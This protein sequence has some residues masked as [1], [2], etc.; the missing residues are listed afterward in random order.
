MQIAGKELA[1]LARF[2]THVPGL[3]EVL[4]GGLFESGV[5]IVQGSPGVGK[6]TLGNQICFA[7][8]RSGGRALYLTLL[9]ESHARMMQH[10][11]AQT[12]FDPSAIPARIYYI[13]AYRELESDGLKGILALLR[14]ELVRQHASLLVI[15][16]VLMP[17]DSDGAAEQRMKEFVHELQSVA[18]ILG[19]NVLMLTSGRGRSFDP[20]QTMVD[21]IFLMEDRAYGMREERVFQVSKFRGSRTARGRHSYCITNHGVHI[22][23]RLEGMP[24]EEP[25]EAACVR[26]VTSG[27]PALDALFSPPG[28]GNATCTLVQGPGGTGKTLLGLQF[29]SKCS[30][31]EPGLMLCF[32]EPRVRLAEMAASIGLDFAA[33][34]ERGHAQVRWICP[35]DQVLDQLGHELLAEIDTGRV[36]RLVVDGIAGLADTSMFHERGYRFLSALLHE[37]RCRGVTA[38]FVSD[39]DALA[40]LGVAHVSHGLAVLFDNVID[41][42]L[43]GQARALHVL[44]ARGRQYA[45]AEQVLGISPHGLRIESTPPPG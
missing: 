2:Q 7:H 32:N 18:T 19:C 22:Y 27:A 14:G 36:R 13:S 6:T 1:P 10:M 24:L 9:A 41:M 20:E 16:G 21:G 5:Y 33:M 28:I 34:S 11:R 25:T 12:F 23:P 38:Y 3:D 26:F 35:G 39:A 43:R 45:Q 40:A 44:K 30:P 31:E 37:L 42:T 8:V 17:S 15:D 4:E 29:L